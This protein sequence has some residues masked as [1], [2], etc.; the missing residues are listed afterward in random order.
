MDQESI[1]DIEE[2]VESISPNKRAWVL[3]ILRCLDDLGG[4][5]K[6]KAVRAR[7]PDLFPD[8]LSD[9]QWAHVIRTQRIGWVRWDMMNANLLSSENGV[10]E[11]SDDGKA[12]L[13]SHADDVLALQVNVPSNDGDGSS[14]GESDEGQTETVQVTDFAAYYIPVLRILKDGVGK[15]K[16]IKVEFERRYLSQL[17][18]GDL[19]SMTKGRIVWKFRMSWALSGLKADGEARNPSRG[20]WEIT[21]T[22][23]ARLEKE[24]KNWRIEGFQ[25]SHASVLVAA[26]A[27]EKATLEP[28]TGSA[29]ADGDLDDHAWSMVD[30][31]NLE[32]R[33][34]TETFNL[35]TVR[36][37]PEQGASAR[38]SRNLILYGPPGTGK[39]HIAK[40]IGR[41]LTGEQE[42]SEDGRF[43][44][45]QFHPSYS[46]EDFV[47][48]LK[49]DLE[50][51]DLRYKLHKG[52]FL[53]ICEAAADEPGHFHVLLIDEINR[54]DPARIFGELM[55]AL[56]YRGEVVRLALGGSLIVPPNLVVIGTMNSVDR[57]VAL[58]DYALRRRF[59]FVRI[60]PDP[61]VVARHLGEG[62]HVGRVAADVLANFNGW[63]TNRLDREHALGHSFFLA[64]K[65]ATDPKAALRRVWQMDV[66]PL[67]DEYLFGNADALREARL[68]WENRVRSAVD[69]L[70]E[71]GDGNAP[72]AQP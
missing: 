9:E 6:P 15:K 40:E 19:R 43:Q 60:D 37:Q 14:G 26:P 11:I 55:Y 34:R 24:D 44:M 61:E 3:P 63:L 52:P 25:D 42:P 70:A 33:I 32:D 17:L 4:R 68:E 51:K 35:L 18:P 36:L 31:T 39:T 30:W 16:E 23:E 54:G 59:G 50:T 66:E 64:L 41:A 1:R 45:V 12:Y 7:M 20:V 71:D 2:R 22:G 48:G 10:W 58:V 27:R 65:G 57:S 69:D 29:P 8:Q 5:A 47:Q 46:Y 67:L 21:D 62:S 56:E 49:P 38:V 72:G 53:E 28:A 13:A